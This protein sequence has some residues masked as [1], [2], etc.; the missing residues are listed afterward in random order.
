MGICLLGNYELVAPNTLTID[1]LKLLIT[2]KLYKEQLWPF[3][4]YLHPIGDPNAL[5]LPVVVGHQ[6]GCATACP[7]DSVYQ[8]LTLI[9][10]Q[11][12]QELALCSFPAS[13]HNNLE[14]YAPS[15]ETGTYGTV[16]VFFN[17]EAFDLVEINN[18]LGET[19]YKAITTGKNAVTIEHLPTGLYVL[20]AWSNDHSRS[21]KFII[22]Y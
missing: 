7:G 9:K 18:I 8:L 20:R 6:D 17:N 4:T 1:A 11:V 12:Q 13:S 3:D 14:A 10:T 15:I 16:R 21:H 19:V 5:A 22:A 2:W